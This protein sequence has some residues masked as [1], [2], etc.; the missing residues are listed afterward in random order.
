MRPTDEELEQFIAQL[1]SMVVKCKRC[2]K[3]GIWP[4]LSLCPQCCEDDARRAKQ[5]RYES[6]GRFRR[7]LY[8][9][10]AWAGDVDY[11]DW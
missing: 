11:L 9:V 5:A 10:R 2:G 4:I 7:W 6:S 1:K 8:R 3:T